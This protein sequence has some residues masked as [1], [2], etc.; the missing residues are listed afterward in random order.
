LHYHIKC[1]KAYMHSR[2]RHRVTEFQKVLNR[3]KTEVATT[4]RKTARYVR[5]RPAFVALL[6]DDLQWKDDVVPLSAIIG[7]VLYPMYSR[8]QSKIS[9]RCRPIS[10]THE[11]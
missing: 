3:A 5:Y 2:M 6:S 8:Y 1:S 9:T 10:C 11:V 7:P 4:E